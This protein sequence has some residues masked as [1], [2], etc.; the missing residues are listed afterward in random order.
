MRSATPRA[1]STD[2]TG[3]SLPGTTGTPGR[4]MSRRAPTLSPI[5]WITRQE[6]PMKISPAASQAWAKRQFS[7]RKP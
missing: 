1:A 3:P 7:E 2:S 4:A 5:C 6:G